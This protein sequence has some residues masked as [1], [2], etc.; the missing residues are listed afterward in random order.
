MMS[1]LF[2]F[3]AIGRVKGS[4]GGKVEPDSFFDGFPYHH[5]AFVPWLGLTIVL[6]FMFVAMWWTLR[7][8]HRK[9]PQ[10]RGF[11]VKLVDDTKNKS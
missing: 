5:P 1:L 6:V 8:R 4:N 11:E 10:Q 7:R 2:R 3:V 9:D